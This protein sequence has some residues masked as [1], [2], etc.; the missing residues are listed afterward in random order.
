V[1]AE[2]IQASSEWIKQAIL[3][4]PTAQDNKKIHQGHLSFLILPPKQSS[5]KGYISEIAN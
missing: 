2:I 1:V 3:L 4:T 5:Q